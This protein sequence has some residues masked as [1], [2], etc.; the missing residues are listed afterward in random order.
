MSYTDQEMKNFTQIAYA[1]FAVAYDTLCKTNPGRTS[2]TIADLAKTAKE[3]NANIDLSCIN[4]L[5]D[6]QKN[7]WS[8]S[9][10]MDHN[11]Q[12]GFYA[13]VIK[14]A[15]GEAAVA[16][17]GS[18]DWHDPSNL[19]N[20][21]I[22]AD[23]GL[24]NSTGTSQHKEVRAF[25]NEM[26]DTLDGYDSLTMTGHSLGGNLAEYATIVSRDYGL[27]DNIKRCVSFDGPGFSDE[28]LKEYSDDIAR[29]SGLM[30]H[31]RWSF[32]GGLLFDLPGSYYV[33]CQVTPEGESE[34]IFRH[35][36]KYLSFDENG[37]I[38]KGDRDSL[39][40]K[41]DDFI[42]QFDES[43]GK[44]VGFIMMPFVL[45]KDGFCGIK[46]AFHTALDNLVNGAKTF[47]KNIHD[48]IH[49][50]LNRNEVFF[51]VNTN[52]LMSSSGRVGVSISRVRQYVAEMFDSV[53]S[54]N[55]M[56]K[57]PANAA[58]SAKFA[59]ERNAIDKYLDRI[60]LYVNSIESDSRDYENCENRALSIASSLRF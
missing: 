2:F 14:T 26:K 1:D 43:T 39:S 58:F 28:F 33:T 36:T 38:I 48:A 10:I 17:R 27:A 52:S 6:E 47:Y 31:Y 3:F 44:V 5:T 9:G 49:H 13:C 37:N 12:T 40:V 16:F 11:S 25:L 8:I 57:G 21:W 7:N 50:Y 42:K 45:V 35:D 59:Q 20:D 15:P 18:E 46:D 24:L 29:M 51:R 30:T 54:L 53:Q 22:K 32:V 56:W 60:Q 55:G 23:I 4:C 19:W 41:T 34:P